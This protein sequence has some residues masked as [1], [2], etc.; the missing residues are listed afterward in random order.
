MSSE[1]V[2]SE[3]VFTIIFLSVLFC[4]VWQT[5]VFQMDALMQIFQQQIAYEIQV[6]HLKKFYHT[7][8]VLKSILTPET[9]RVSLSGLFHYE[10][11]DT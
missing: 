11:R 9:K 5:I 1:G 3:V 7:L 6:T 2:K 8:Y 10:Y 4:S